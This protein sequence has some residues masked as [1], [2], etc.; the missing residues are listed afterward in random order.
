MK[1]PILRSLYKPVRLLRGFTLIELMVTIA[2]MV[3]LASLAAPALGTFVSR[4][5]M[6][7]VSADFT[8]AFQRARSEAI[9]RNECV[10]ICM[11]NNATSASPSC[12]SGG[13]ENWRVGWIV[14][15]Y[16]QCT[17]TVNPASA[18]DMVL[19]R[20]GTSARYTLN[21]VDN[22]RS[23]VFNAR[24]APRSGASKFNLLDTQ[25]AVNGPDDKFNRTF[26]LD[27]VGRVRTVEYAA[28]CT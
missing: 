19:A 26:C 10:A 15:R 4:S 21:N 5:T 9:N 28:S 23:V 16:P 14:F 11:S 8:L 18:E 24:G 17:G 22:V 13:A 20:E 25:A 1:P 12:M 7:G 27:F 3:I 2:V 6:R